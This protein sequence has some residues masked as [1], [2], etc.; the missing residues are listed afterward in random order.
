M[1]GDKRARR[2]A[3]L[4]GKG[5]VGKTVIAANLAASF[6]SAGLR[7]LLVDA[8]LGLANVD[9]I[10][11]L[12][13]R[14]TLPEHLR[15][16][17]TFD[18]LLMRA[19]AGFDV[20][21]AGSGL[22]EG[23]YLTTPVSQSLEDIVRAVDRRYDVVLFDAGAGIGE[24]VMFFARAADTVLLVATPEPTSL[25]DAYATI[26][27]LSLRF[28]IKQFEL[29][30]NQADPARAAEIGAGIVRSLQDVSARF[31]AGAA[32]DAVQLYLAAAVPADP[33]IP[34]SVSR[35]RLL[36]E[37]MPQSPAARAISGLASSLLAPRPAGAARATSIPFGL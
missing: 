26:K 10:L 24:I 19:P 9:V 29:V 25:T 37:I 35:R 18:Q 20:L 33:A 3:I 16:Q 32:G 12:N 15:G 34:E 27:V 23:T 4:S 1:D 21:P 13:P 6:A 30:V 5:G 28:G 8:D 7:T 11:G 31:L 14:H 36:A 22:V 2:I 17:C